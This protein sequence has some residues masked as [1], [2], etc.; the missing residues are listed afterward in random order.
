MFLEIY[1]VLYFVKMKKYFL[2]LLSNLFLIFI[3]ITPP[4]LATTL[5]TVSGE[6]I[7]QFHC[8]GCHPNGSNIIRRGKN[9]QWKALHRY[10]YDSET[11]IAQIVTYGK[12]NM[13]A[14]KERLTET[15]INQ[16]SKYVLQ[17]AEQNWKS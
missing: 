17:Q 6:Q 1:S 10:G 12:N 9:L 13:S 16:V 5:N 11:A 7:F 14:F 2:S 4:S 8:A 15:E 3:L